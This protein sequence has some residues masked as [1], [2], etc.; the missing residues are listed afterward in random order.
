MLTHPDFKPRRTPWQVVRLSLVAGLAYGMLAGSAIAQTARVLPADAKRSQLTVTSNTTATV[1]DQ[2]LRFAPGLRIISQE[3]RLLR[4][5]QLAG[6]TLT[7][8]Y[9]LDLYGQLLTAWVLTDEE[10]RRE[11]P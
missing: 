4:P 11:S 1:G 6:Q 3:N 2:T 10:L 7:V 5:Q 9:K 8:R